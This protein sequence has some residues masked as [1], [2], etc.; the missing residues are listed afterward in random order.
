MENACGRNCERLRRNHPIFKPTHY[1]LVAMWILVLGHLSQGSVA[2]ARAAF[3]HALKVRQYLSPGLDDSFMAVF[4]D[5][6]DSSPTT[7]ESQSLS[8]T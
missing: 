2:E 4:V 3:Q 6:L 7:P 1:P 8:P 5:E